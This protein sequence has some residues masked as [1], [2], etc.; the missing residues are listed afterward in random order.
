LCWAL[1]YCLPALMRWTLESYIN[2]WYGELKF[3]ENDLDT[4]QPS[5][6]DFARH[7]IQLNAIN[8]GMRNFDAPPEFMKRL[9]MLQKHT[10]FVREKL[11]TL[12]GR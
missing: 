7:S 12:R 1:C 11:H 2:R 9:F 8:M 3:I 5:G 6:L 4:T 10:E